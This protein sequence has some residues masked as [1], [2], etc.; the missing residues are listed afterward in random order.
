MS[1][2]YDFILCFTTT[3]V[4][5]PRPAPTQVL[6]SFKRGSRLAGSCRPMHTYSRC[7]TAAGR[8]PAHRRVYILHFSLG[9]AKS[10]FCSCWVNLTP[11]ILFG[12]ASLKQTRMDKS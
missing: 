9:N 2:L 10:G 8:Q 1:L 12:Q 5:P 3:R 7:P 6:L 4:Q 11:V